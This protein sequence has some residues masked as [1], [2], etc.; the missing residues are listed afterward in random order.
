MEMK[1]VCL[2]LT[3]VMLFFASCQV[4]EQAETSG[5]ISAQSTAETENEAKEPR[6]VTDGEK[7]P[8]DEILGSMTLE[9]KIMQLFFVTPEAVGRGGEVKT[10]D[11]DFRAKAK[12]TCVG[13]IILFAKN[14]TDRQQ[15]TD[16]TAEL[17]ADFDIPVFIGVDEEGGSVSRLSK[18]CGVTDAGNMA[19]V[20]T[21]D[22]AGSIGERLGLEL[23]ELGFNVDFAPVADVI[24]NKNNTEIGKRSFGTDPRDVAGKVAA[25]TEGMQSEGVSSVLKHFPGHGST[26]NNSH[27]GT[28]VSLRTLD[29]L[30]AEELVPFAAGIEAGADFVMA[31]HM[32]L[33]N[34]TGDETPC[35]LS[36]SIITS[37]L[38][39]E[40]G[41]D[42]VVITD[43]LN[44]GAVKGYGG[45]ACVFAIEAG[46][47]MLLM[48]EDLDIAYSAVFE[49]VEN[50]R[51][52]EE[53]IN[54][55]VIRILKLKEKHG[56]I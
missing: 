4:G 33:P 24:I 31:S 28:S 36:P 10:I 47:D 21:A 15:V 49:A 46:C 27:N 2:L 48:P 45:E 34:V 8:A 50:G 22:Q 25:L 53:R 23:R 19:D 43:G 41:Y 9:Q 13:G 26:V 12:N 35:S 55:S 17:A 18:K 51:I 7:D 44:M 54:E 56:L 37:L 29:E 39:D 5:N 32:S 30:R 6:T 3:L 1:R 42:G 16:L 11:A 40:L 52:T 38:R 14:V 20:E